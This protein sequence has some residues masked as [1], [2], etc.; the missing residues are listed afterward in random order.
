MQTENWLTTTGLWNT[1]NMRSHSPTDTVLKKVYHLLHQVLPDHLEDL[2][3]LEHLLQNIDRQVPSG[4]A[5]ST[6]HASISCCKKRVAAI[7]SRSQL[8]KPIAHLRSNKVKLMLKPLLVSV[9]CSHWFI[10]WDNLGPILDQHLVP[11]VHQGCLECWWCK[12]EM[13]MNMIAMRM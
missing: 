6:S 2:V 3:L 8:L 4:T 9:N 11:S 13:M 1:I 10:Q 7:Q 5:P 12:A